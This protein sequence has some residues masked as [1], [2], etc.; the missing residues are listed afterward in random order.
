MYTIDLLLKK[1]L[2]NNDQSKSNNQ[3]KKVSLMKNN[4]ELLKQ[5]YILFSKNSENKS[6]NIES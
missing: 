2:I 3:T 4:T 1:N 5:M 6:L